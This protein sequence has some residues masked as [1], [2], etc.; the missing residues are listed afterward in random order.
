MK[1]GD[2]MKKNLMILAM[3]I[4]I[5]LMGSFVSA[6]STQGIN[7]K[8]AET[9]NLIITPA[10]LDFGEIIQGSVDNVPTNGPIKFSAG[11]GSNANMNVEFTSVTA[12]GLFELMEIETETAVWKLIT[13]KP[14]VQ[15][16]CTVVED[17]CTY[18]DKDVNAKLKVP[19]GYPAG[20]K[21][22][23]ITYTVTG[24]APICTP[25]CSG[26]VCGGGDGCGGSCAITCAGICNEGVCSIV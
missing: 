8:I 9:I 19:A 20:T 6:E 25:D 5:S 17:I 18:A 21:T 22:G 11:A 10:N 12:N 13:T 16:T 2:K 4:C 24:A 23:I 7:V 15:L 3:L 26:K 14:V 1:G